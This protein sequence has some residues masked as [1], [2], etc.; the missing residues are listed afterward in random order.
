M[1]ARAFIPALCS[2]NRDVTGVPPHEP[3]VAAKKP[4]Q[5][6]LEDGT[7]F[8]AFACPVLTKGHFAVAQTPAIMEYLGKKHGYLPDGA[9]AQ[10]NCL[11]MA[12]NAADLW[13]EVC[14]PVSPVCVQRGRSA[15]RALTSPVFRRSGVHVCTCSLVPSPCRASAGIHRQE[16]R[17]RRAR[18]SPRTPSDVARCDGQGRG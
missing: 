9:E 1:P 10:A 16:G 17:R 13:A 14:A 18:L 6:Y 2:S 7:G 8:P 11:Q 15:V 5:L 3:P 12:L 4:F